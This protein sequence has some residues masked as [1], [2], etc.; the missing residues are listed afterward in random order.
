MKRSELK[1]GAVLAFRRSKNEDH[2]RFIDAVVVLA[3]EPYETNEYTGRITKSYKGKGN[4]VLVRGVGREHEVTVQLSQLVG[5]YDTTKAAYE[6]REARFA[7]EKEIHAIEAAKRQATREAAL[8]P[9]LAGLKELAPNAWISG[10][11]KIADLSI[12]LMNQITAA[13]AAAGK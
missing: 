8:E 9:L 12:D 3:V 13:I 6:A 2:S 11:M 4:G 7:A 10:D 5:D 1:V